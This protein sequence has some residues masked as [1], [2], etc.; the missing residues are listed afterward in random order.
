MW[1]AKREEVASFRMDCGIIFKQ[2]Q[3]LRMRDIDCWSVDRRPFLR[4]LG[5]EQ[6]LQLSPK[7]GKFD[8]FGTVETEK[9]IKKTCFSNEMNEFT[10]PN[11]TFSREITLGNP[12]SV[13]E[14]S[15]NVERSH[16][17]K[18]PKRG[19]RDGVNP[20]FHDC[21]MNRRNGTAQAERDKN[22]Y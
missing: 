16:Q 18:P 14:C 13:K 10:Y 17:N 20:P 15:E 7:R 8:G 4:F 11:I 2:G 9:I 6:K 3:L 19:I 22:S 5:S 1:K 21:I 12:T